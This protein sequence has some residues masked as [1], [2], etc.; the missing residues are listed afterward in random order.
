MNPQIATNISGFGFT[1]NGGDANIYGLEAE[2]RANLGLGWDF[3]TDWGYTHSK[4]LT[5]SA[6]DGIP[7]GFSVPDTPKVT[8]SAS[9]N[10]HHDLGDDTAFFGNVTYSFVGSRYDLP[11]G[12]TVYQNNI[13]QTAINLPSYGILNLRAGFRTARWSAALFVNNATNKQV[14]L[15]PLPQINLAI[16][17]FTRYIVNQP[18]TY[19]LDVTYKFGK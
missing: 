6:I 1:V 8:G 13:N 11:Y 18:V 12:V 2:F 9:M 16:P 4:F 14:L 19:G 10:Y 7:S 17:Q 5:D 3:S 15:D